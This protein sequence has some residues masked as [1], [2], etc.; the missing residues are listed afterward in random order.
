MPM[1]FGEFSSANRH[2][3][4]APDGFNHAL[5]S[6]DASD[7]MTATMGELGEAANIVKKL[8]RFRDGINGNK[9]TID[10]LRAK[11]RRELGDTF[12]YLDLF[13]QSLGFSI[14]DAACEVFDRKSEEIGYPIKLGVALTEAEGGR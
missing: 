6:W 14:A 7:W 2:R 3:C 10:E 13:C 4:E 1:T 8:N 9:E 12:V 5:N 11:L